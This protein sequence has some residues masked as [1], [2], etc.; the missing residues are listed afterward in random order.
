M[1]GTGATAAGV[2]PGA[3]RYALGLLVVVYVFNAIDRQIMNVLVEPV[4]AELGVSDQQ[5]GFLVGGAF[6]IFYT[7]AGL[8]IARW[9]DRGTRRTIIA[10]AL[11]AWS[12]MTVASGLSRTFGQ[13]LLARIGVGV[14]EA[15]CSPASHSLISDY[16]PLQ[17]RG[18]A[19]AL[20]QAGGQVGMLS[21]FILGGYLAETYGWRTAFFVVGA[22]GLLLA[23][24]VQ[25]T[26]REPPRGLSDRRD[27]ST[28]IE[29]LGSVLRFIW[30]LPSLR[31]VLAATSLQTLVIAAQLTFNSSVLIRVHEMSLTHVGLA[32]GLINGLVGGIFTFAGGYFG[33]RLQRRDLRW[34]L[35]LPA[36]GA[37]LSVPLSIAA[38]LSDDVVATILLLAAASAGYHLF[39]ALGHATVQS[40]VRPRMRATMSAIALLAM[41][42]VGFLIGPWLAGVISD[43]LRPRFGE[44]SIRY[45]L[46][47]VS[48]LML[49]AVLH[50]GLAA[51]TYREDLLAKTREDGASA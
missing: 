25:L 46:L 44:E 43:L 27:V 6:A 33:D 12:A 2:R 19:L 34:Y 28:E 15:G 18:T 8:P 26:L 16:F 14:G 50:Y 23:V 37:L 29:P 30:G 31:H 13:L 7:V 51:R 39:A 21:G 45:A 48:L 36:A 11:A 9:A 24:V 1:T 49:W 32:L 20:Y 17:Q 40:L 22:P 3:G 5:L 38:Y 35:W 42:L 47:G 10:L 4:R 41:N